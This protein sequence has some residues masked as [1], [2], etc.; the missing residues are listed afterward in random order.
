MSHRTRSALAAQ[1]VTPADCRHSREPFDTAFRFINQRHDISAAAKLVH[2]HLVTLHRTGRDATQTEIGEA[3]GMSRHQVWR[4]ITE[5]VAAE[6]VQTIRVGLGNPNQYVLL[7]IEADDL[8][9]RASGRRPAGT[10][11]AGQPRPRARVPSYPE[12]RRKK[13]RYLPGDLMVSRYG[14][15]QRR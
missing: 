14:R 1:S 8:D 3:V 15:V 6:L 4:A 12:E 11:F 10:A 7:G 13:G 2:A 9:G 5:L